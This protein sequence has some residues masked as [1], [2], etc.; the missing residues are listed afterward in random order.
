MVPSNDTN[1]HTH[2]ATLPGAIPREFCDKLQ[3]Y[4]PPTELVIPEFCDSKQLKPLFGLTRSHAYLLA[5]EGKIRTICLRRKGT[6]RGA[7]FSTVRA[8]AGFLPNAATNTPM[9]ASSNSQHPELWTFYDCRQNGPHHDSG[10]G[11]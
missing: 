1:M 10:T 11:T 3:R 2:P 8:S 6:T 4:S 7:D 5:S 9:V